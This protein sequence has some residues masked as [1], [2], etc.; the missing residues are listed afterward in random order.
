[1]TSYT[2]LHLGVHPHDNVG[3]H[4]YNYYDDEPQ[5]KKYKKRQQRKIK[6]LRGLAAVM[7]N[8]NKAKRKRRQIGLL[9]WRQS[10]SSQQL[11]DAAIENAAKEEKVQHLRRKIEK[12]KVKSREKCAR[13]SARSAMAMH[14]QDVALSVMQRRLQQ[15]R[16]LPPHHPHHPP[17]HPPYTRVQPLADEEDEWAALMSE[18]GDPAAEAAMEMDAAAE[19]EMQAQAKLEAA[20]EMEAEA[21]KMAYAA[22]LQ[23]QMAEHEMSL[24]AE[25]KKPKPLA[26]T[27]NVK[28]VSNQQRMIAVLQAMHKYYAA[29]MTAEAEAMEAEGK[30]ASQL[31]SETQH[32]LS[33]IDKMYKFTS[34]ATH[35]G[36]AMKNLE[37]SKDGQKEMLY[38]LKAYEGYRNNVPGALHS[39]V[40]DTVI[41]NFPKDEKNAFENMD[42]QKPGTWWET[43][44]NL[45]VTLM[46]SP[47]T[48]LAL[49]LGALW[50]FVS[51]AVAGTA[52]IASQLIPR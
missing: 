40:F 4:G 45:P 17:L 24:M 35:W 46:K 50:G 23:Q 22:H 34:S 3:S 41:A 48:M 2:P 28:V 52:V 19:M 21:K 25:L 1:M 44:K 20:A 7:E 13:Q 6:D 9:P 26:S 15:S 29:D 49:Q 32:L 38:L 14:Q 42:V 16:M 5:K 43:I 10:T 12:L 33:I 39:K 51:P 8:E 27:S 31:R 30:D 11:M 47:L 18:L 36:I 37:E